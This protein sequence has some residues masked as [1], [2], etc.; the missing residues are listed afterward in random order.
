MHFNSSKS[1]TVSSEGKLHTLHQP[2]SSG[3]WHDRCF[4]CHDDTRVTIHRQQL[5]STACRPLAQKCTSHVEQLTHFS[6]RVWGDAQSCPWPG[7]HPLC[8]ELTTRWLDEWQVCRFI[9]NCWIKSSSP[10]NARTAPPIRRLDSAGTESL[11]AARLWTDVL[12]VW[13][14]DG[15]KALKLKKLKHRVLHSL[16]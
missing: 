4:H 16:Q 7:H 10:H 14:W 13:H 15:G 5:I 12:A 2:F 11:C 1:V 3:L 6:F 9:F 8:V